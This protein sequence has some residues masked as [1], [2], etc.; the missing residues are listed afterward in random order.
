[1]YH[2]IWLSIC[3]LDLDHSDVGFLAFIYNHSIKFCFKVDNYTSQ[4]R[5]K[6]RQ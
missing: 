6:R 3:A 1:M 4:Y 2:C 5:L